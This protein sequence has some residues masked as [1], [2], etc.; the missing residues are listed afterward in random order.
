MRVVLQNTID[1]D[2]CEVFFDS[3]PRDAVPSVDL[4][5]EHSDTLKI[6]SKSN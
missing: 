5:L 6:H 2:V 3:T 1:K 4:G